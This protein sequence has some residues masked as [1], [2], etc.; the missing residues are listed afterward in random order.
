MKTFACR[1][2]P[3]EFGD[4]LNWVD[5]DEHP[6]LKGCLIDGNPLFG[7]LPLNGGEATDLMDVLWR[8]GYRPSKEC[9]PDVHRDFKHES[10]LSEA[11]RSAA[12]SR[13]VAT[14]RPLEDM[15]AIA[16]HATGAK[17]CQ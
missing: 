2:N 15:R 1:P 6:E 8:A 9:A 5:F 11:G 7:A 17:P 16:F 4:V 3:R 12:L 14:E 13:L 10:E